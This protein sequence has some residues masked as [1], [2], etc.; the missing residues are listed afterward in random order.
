MRSA[1]G[2]KIIRTAMNNWDDG[3]DVIEEYMT[4]NNDNRK[5]MRI[6]KVMKVTKTTNYKV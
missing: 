5:K 1:M 3:D 4:Y 2:L 6:A